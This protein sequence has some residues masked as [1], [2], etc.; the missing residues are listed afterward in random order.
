MDLI[1]IVIAAA[2]IVWNITTFMMYSVDKRRA[3]KGQWRIKESTLIL[4]AF[5]MGGAGAFLGMTLLRHKTKH[6]KFRLL[7]PVALLINVLVVI[8][9]CWTGILN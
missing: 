9:V 5:L 7:L 4:V 8:G 6:L 1:L 2:L 3:G